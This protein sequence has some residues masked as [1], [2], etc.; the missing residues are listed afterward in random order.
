MNSDISSLPIDQDLFKEYILQKYS[1]NLTL[2]DAQSEACL[3]NPSV[4][5][6][7][8]IFNNQEGIGFYSNEKKFEKNNEDY[9]IER[10]ACFGSV[11][12]PQNTKYN[13]YYVT[14][15][16]GIK[17]ND[18][19]YGDLEEMKLVQ[20]LYDDV[21]Y[22]IEEKDKESFTKFR[23]KFEKNF[24]GNYILVDFNKI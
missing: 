9:D 2:Y 18:E 8:I 15:Y 10:L 6:T 21:Q 22:D 12:R 17:N 14:V 16:V 19:I 3:I 23:Y 20:L 24:E 4:H 13:Y 5:I 7:G 11:F 1:P